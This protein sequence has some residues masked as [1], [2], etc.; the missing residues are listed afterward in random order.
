MAVVEIS[1]RGLCRADGENFYIPF[2]G[3]HLVFEC[4]K[5]VNCGRIKVGTQKV[6][7]EIT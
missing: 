1:E 6:V 3:F 7:Q 5:M 2:S 4:V